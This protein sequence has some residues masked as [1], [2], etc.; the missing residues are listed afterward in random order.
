MDKTYVQPCCLKQQ[1]VVRLHVAP[2]LKDNLTIEK[3]A[4]EIAAIAP[5][6]DEKHFVSYA[7][8]MREGG[9]T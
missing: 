1:Q 2:H 3:I 7:K 8:E 9:I 5:E 6:F 4:K